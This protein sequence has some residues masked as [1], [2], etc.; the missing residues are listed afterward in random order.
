MPHAI[1]P[2]GGDEEHS[3]DDI[4][5]SQLGAVQAHNHDAV[6]AVPGTAAVE[7]SPELVR[8]MQAPPPPQSFLLSTLSIS[9][10]ADQCMHEINLYHRGV[11]Q[12]DM[13]CVELLRR[14]TLQDDQDAWQAVQQCLGEQV[15]RWLDGHPRQEML[16]RLDKEEYVVTQ[17]FERFYQATVRQQLA[18]NILADAL[19]SLRAYL[20]SAL[21]DALR[22]STR[23]RE[24]PVPKHYKAEQSGAS[25]SGQSDVWE[26]ISTLLPDLREQRLASLLFRCGLKPKDITR[27]YPQEFQDVEEI[28]SLRCRLIQ[29][30]L[31]H[32]DQ[33]GW[34]RDTAGK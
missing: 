27:T 20:N 9:S 6:T 1:V 29:Q 12:G 25:S 22:A 32:M 15:R 13:Y 14:A 16:C 3:P 11:F 17:A 5:S 34:S 2:S 19:H 18:F 28:F 7:L 33:L 23:S 21:L 8:P 26:M 10:L 31:D 30:L 24:I 4:R